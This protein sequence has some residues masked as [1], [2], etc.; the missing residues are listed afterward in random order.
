[1]GELCRII[2]M[3]RIFP[4]FSVTL[5]TT[6]GGMKLPFRLLLLRRYNENPKNQHLVC[7]VEGVLR[8]SQGEWDEVLNAFCIEG[9]V[10]N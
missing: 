5:Q 4:L 7:E 6:K 8:T 9:S 3:V 10:N 1:M 2:G